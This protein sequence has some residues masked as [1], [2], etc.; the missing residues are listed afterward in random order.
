MP[1]RTIKGKKVRFQDKVNACKKNV[2]PRDPNQTKEEACKR[3]IGS[4]IIKEK[5]K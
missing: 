3:I 5:K 1:V 4:Q 2:T